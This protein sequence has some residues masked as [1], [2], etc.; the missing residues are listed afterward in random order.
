MSIRVHTKGQ[1]SSFLHAKIKFALKKVDAMKESL[2]GHISNK[3]NVADVMTDIVYG[4][5]RHIKS[6]ISSTT[7]TMMSRANFQS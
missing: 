1:S 7:L 4:K 6:S 5:K 2:T 3:K